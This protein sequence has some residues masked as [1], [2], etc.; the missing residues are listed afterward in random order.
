MYDLI[1]GIIDHTYQT[2]TAGDQQYLYYICGAVIIIC[3]IWALDV[4]RGIFHWRAK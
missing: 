4:L 2:Q 3:F 1:K